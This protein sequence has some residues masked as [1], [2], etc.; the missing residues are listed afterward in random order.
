MCPSDCQG[1]RA[2]SAALL[3]LLAE[4]DLN[5]LT[6]GEVAAGCG[7]GEEV[8]AHTCGR[9]AECALLAHEE[10]FDQLYAACELALLHDG[11]WHERVRH[12]LEAVIDLFLEHPGMTRLCLV[13][14][15]GA[16]LPGLR[17][18]RA[19]TRGLFVTLLVSEHERSP[20]EDLLPRLHFELLAGAACRLLQDEFLAGRLDELRDS[21]GRLEQLVSVFEPVPA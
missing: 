8:A 4:R 13:E 6:I 12:G 21:P 16:S 17:E 15:D 5:S 11:P 10:S 1:C 2:L 18:Q 20:E 19:S 3:E 9:L 7:L 14:T